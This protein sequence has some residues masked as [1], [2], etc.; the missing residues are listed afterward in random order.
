MLSDNP[1]S[2][3]GATTPTV[4]APALYPPGV[5]PPDQP[6]PILS[7]LREFPKN[8]LR[9]VPRAV[10]E[11]DIFVLRRKAM[12]LTY[13]WISGPELVEEILIRRPG[14]LVKSQVEKR[15][16]DKSVGESVLTADGARWRWQRRVLAPLFRHQEIVAY[17]PKMAE[18]ADEQI[19]TWR[20]AGAGLRNVDEDMTVATLAVIMRTML[21]KSDTGTASRIM[22]AT[23]T[24]LSKASWEA[25]Y[26]IL[27]VP[28]WMPH[29]GTWRMSQSARTLRG[30]MEA[31]IAERRADGGADEDLLGRLLSARDPE[32]DAPMDEEGLI[33]NLSTLL[34][35]GHETTAKALG[36]TLYLLARSP[37]W[38]DAVREEVSQVVGCGGIS[39]THI[40]QLSITARVLKESMRL[41]PPA[42]VVARV[43]TEIIRAGDENLP[44]GS[45]LVFPVYAIHRHKKRWQ[46][47]ARF[48]PDRFLP[49]REAALP[50]GQYMPFGV[51]PRICIGQ[52]FAMIEATTL[53]ASFIRAAR[54][55]W[56]GKH[57]PEPISR[58]TLRPTGGMPLK[59]TPI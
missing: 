15:V 50:R 57:E 28:T 44:I 25:A 12:G 53:L 10:Y 58:V 6:L 49:E 30:I 47:P 24:Y 23:E 11:R 59:V 16:F 8:P 29:P 48:D 21:G 52:A 34:L 1:G 51:G 39:A 19:A 20:A 22:D 14:A 3:N 13:A 2:R 9:S 46:D 5:T 41:Y 36:W 56:D 17:V 4:A 37:E 45:N 43:N 40:D 18:A 26:A 7:F 54:F 32:T 42:P 33:N 55:E 38:Q 35:A 31:L 27:R